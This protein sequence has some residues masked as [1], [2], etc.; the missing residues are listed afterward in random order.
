[1]PVLWV[2]LKHG[3]NWDSRVAF[4]WTLRATPEPACQTLPKHPTGRY[5]VLD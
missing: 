5:L 2:Y 3:D 4:D 1:M